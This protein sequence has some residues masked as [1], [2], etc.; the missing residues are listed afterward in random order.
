M[1]GCERWTIKKAKRRRIDAFELWC[2][3]KLLRVPWIA[4]RSNQSILKEIRPEHSLEGLVLK[5]KF[6]S[7]GH[8]M[9]RTDSLEK[10]TLMLGKIEGRTRRA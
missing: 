5:L 3:R 7:F 10:K 6:E 9:E 4:R 2:W 1:D 8:L